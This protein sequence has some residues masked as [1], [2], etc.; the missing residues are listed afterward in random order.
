V[1]QWV[2]EKK[3]LGFSDF[4]AAGM[5]TVALFLHQTKGWGSFKEE[6]AAKARETKKSK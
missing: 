3:P 5:V 1:V 4:I 6:A 2:H